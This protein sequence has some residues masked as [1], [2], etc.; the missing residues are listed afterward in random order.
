MKLL[1]ESRNKLRG[2]KRT[3]EKAFQAQLKE[4]GRETS[5][6]KSLLTEENRLLRKSHGAEVQKR[7]KLEAKSVRDDEKISNLNQ[8]N[9]QLM[10]DLLQERRA[11]NI[12]I[13]EAMVEAHRLSAE[14]LEMT[15]QANKIRDRAE[16]RI[17]TERNRFSAMLHQ[18]RAHHSR[19]SEK[20]R[21]KQATSNELYR[22]VREDIEMLSK[23]LKEQHVIWQRRLSENDLSTKD[24]LSKERTRRRNIV[25]QQIDRSSA[26]EGQLMEIIE[27]LV[28]MN[29]E[30]VEEVKSAKKARQEAVKL[31]NKSKEDAARR[32]DQLR[33]EKE[34][35][36]LLR[37]DL[38]RALKLQLAQEAQLTE[39]KSMVETFKSSK[40]HLSYEFKAGRRQGPQWPLWVTEVCCELLVNGS[41]PSAIPVSIATLFSALYGEEPKKIPSLNFVQQCRVLV[42]IIS[43]TITAM[44]LAACPN[45]AEIFFDATT[46]CQVPFSAVV[47]SLMGDGPETIDPIIVSSCVILEDE[48]SEMQVDGIVTKVRTQISRTYVI[49]QQLQGTHH[50]SLQRLI[51]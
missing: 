2:G 46:R 29:D 28:V 11:S 9:N 18:E 25:Q 34:K 10:V 6:V 14:A 8:A 38:S 50:Y 41:P 22:Q 32:L 16:D 5:R 49:A 3:S 36:N 48:T 42:Q 27:G 37:D 30:L 7:Q 51:L 40:R 47:I 17:V 1:V 12:I 21:Q 19:K 24:R 33:H 39:Y 43:E 15:L 13:D 35:K 4:V 26:V 23:K 45:W 44:K 31:Y 20:L